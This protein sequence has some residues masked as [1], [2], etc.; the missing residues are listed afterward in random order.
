MMAN[1]EVYDPKARAAPDHMH[2]HH[3]HGMGG[4]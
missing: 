2:E 1:I 3:M 4:G